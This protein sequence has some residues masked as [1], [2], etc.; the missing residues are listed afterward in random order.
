MDPMTLKSTWQRRYTR[1]GSST[2]ITL[3]NCFA[4]SLTNQQNPA[5]ST[6]MLQNPTG[7][8]SFKILKNPAGSKLSA[9]QLSRRIARNFEDT[10]THL[11]ILKNPAGSKSSAMPKNPAGSPWTWRK[12]YKNPYRM[13]LDLF[14]ELYWK[15][16]AGSKWWSMPKNPAK[17]PIDPSGILL[18]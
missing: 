3:L 6:G 11:K 9:L 15:N 10:S 7:F 13:P 16:P 5:G 17:M 4:G 1:H 2:R 12:Y 14:L 8:F 18:F